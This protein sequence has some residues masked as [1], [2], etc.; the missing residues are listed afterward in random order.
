MAMTAHVKKV[1]G[2]V[3][4]PKR[5][6]KA[7]LLVET[8]IDRV[9]SCIPV[10]TRLLDLIDAAPV[11]GA[12]SRG[13]LEA[14]GEAFLREIEEAD[15][16]IIGCPVFQGSYP[17]LFKHV[18][19]LIHPLALRNRPVLISAVG[20][21]LRHSLMVEHHLRPLFGFFEAASVSTA[22]YA[23]AHELDSI[24]HPPEML[25][26]RIANAV[27]QFASL[28][29]NPANAAPKAARRKHEAFPVW[30]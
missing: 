15:A 11:L 4:S 24:D 17:G 18:F 16:L 9:A 26:R 6:A 25:E 5:P 19:D 7:R 27:A 10:E 13:E 29:A 1:V 23:S 14:A 2:F 30:F 12:L 21:G 3:G 28:I 8:I 20:G 22:L